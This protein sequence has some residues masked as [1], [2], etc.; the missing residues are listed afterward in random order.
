MCFGRAPKI[1]PVLAAPDA[2]VLNNPF[3]DDTSSNT[4]LIQSLRTGR[5]SLRI[6]LPGLD[7]VGFGG[8]RTQ[9]AI[10][11]AVGNPSGNARM[12]GGPRGSGRGI[13]DMTDLESGALDRMNA[14]SQPEYREDRRDAAEE[15]AQ[16]RE[17]GD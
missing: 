8:T 1:A 9:A 10:R 11:G 16:R 12:I 6:R 14:R 3:L 7:T 2:E 15:R 4:R 13:R 17:D 5:S